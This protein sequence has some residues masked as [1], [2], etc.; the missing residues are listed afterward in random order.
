MP[1]PALLA[2]LI[3]ALLHASWNLVLKSSSERLVAATTQ[4]ILAGVVLLP[5]VIWRGFPFEATTYLLASAVVQVAYLY[6]LATAYDK[7]DLSFVYPIARGS[8]PVLIALGALVGLSDPVQGLG[9]LA[10]SLICGGVVA[11]G[12]TARTHHGV[13]WSLLTGL[14][15]ASYVTI[16]GTGVRRAGDVLAYI[17]ALSVITAVM[18][19]P[20]VLIARGRLVIRDALRAEWTRHLFAGLASLASYGL[21]LFASRLAPLSLVSAARETAVVFATFGS[22]WYLDERVGR[23][24]AMATA[25]IAAGVGV[26]ALSR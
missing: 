10:L 22:W 11:V 17:S 16:D 2:V 23:T 6:A 19:V 24:R 9:W 5:I 15:I 20:L 18:S 25:V 13:G 8:A 14:L 21:L 4:I 12:L 3:A 7:A 1:V 26:L